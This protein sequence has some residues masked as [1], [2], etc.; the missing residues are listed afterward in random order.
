MNYSFRIAEDRAVFKGLA[1]LR[2][3]KLPAAL[4][5]YYGHMVVEYRLYNSLFFFGQ[6]KSVIS[7]KTYGP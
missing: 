2:C 5:V 3:R 7:G 4:K 1:F 6:Q